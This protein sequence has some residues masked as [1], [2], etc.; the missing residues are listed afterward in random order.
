MRTIKFKLLRLLAVTLLFFGKT[1]GTPVFLANGDK[2]KKPLGLRT[3]PRIQYT[4]RPK[5]R[6][7]QSDWFYRLKSY[8]WVNEDCNNADKTTLKIF[9][10]N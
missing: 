7:S 8:E 5:E 6:L 9:I 2:V 10:L 4:I 1:S 3:R